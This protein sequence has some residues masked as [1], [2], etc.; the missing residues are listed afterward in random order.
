MKCD[1]R[2]WNDGTSKVWS[3][4]KTWILRLPRADLSPDIMVL[5]G[6]Y[7]LAFHYREVKR[8]GG[9]NPKS[10]LV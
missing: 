7:T 2:W 8:V 5:L 1:R 3:E 6:L 10:Y 9:T 4:G